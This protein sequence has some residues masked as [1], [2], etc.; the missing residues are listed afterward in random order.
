V[1]TARNVNVY[2]SFLCVLCVLCLLFNINKT[3]LT[4][5]IKLVFVLLESERESIILQS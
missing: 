2:V 4:H 3:E 1:Y 5:Y